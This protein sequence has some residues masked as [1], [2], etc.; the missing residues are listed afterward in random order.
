[1]E[2]TCWFDPMEDDCKLKVTLYTVE[3]TK[4]YDNTVSDHTI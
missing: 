2:L 4:Q 1:M 3:A